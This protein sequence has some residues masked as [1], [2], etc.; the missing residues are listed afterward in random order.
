M[1]EPIAVE[2]HTCVSCGVTNCR[3]NRR[4]AVEA[5]PAERIAYLVDA[6]WPEYAEMIASARRP[7]DQ[8]I[9]PGL[10][11]RPLPGRYRW[12]APVEHCAGW[13]LSIATCHAAGRPRGAAFVSAATCATIKGRSSPRQVDRLSRSPPRRR[14]GLPATWLG[15]RRARRPQPAF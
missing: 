11:G 14:P 4:H 15:G 6:A 13:P 5:P 8:L 10:L 7:D 3:R 1:T 12:P 2:L 9:A